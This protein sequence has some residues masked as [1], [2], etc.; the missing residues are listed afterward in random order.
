MG[1]LSLII[2]YVIIMKATGQD[3]KASDVFR[4]LKKVLAWGFGG[5]FALSLL[6][7][8]IGSGEMASVA[9]VVGL[10]FL[11]RKIKQKNTQNN[12]QKEK[13]AK[14]VTKSGGAYETRSSIL[15]RPVTKRNKL[16]TQ[17]NERFKLYLTREQIDRIVDASY[18]S[19]GWKTEIEAMMTQDYV[20]IYEWMQGPTAALR[21]YLYAFHVQK[22]SSDF[23]QQDQIVTDS[24]NEIMDYADT[25]KHLDLQQRIEAVNNKF[26]TAFDDV[27]FMIAFRYLEGKGFRHTLDKVNLE[28]NDSELDE[29]MKKYQKEATPSA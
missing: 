3:E 21:A 20:T 29:M 5:L 22:I 1:I 4:I 12:Y 25:L 8:V 11:L 14:T 28:R 10:L 2:V 24:L 17:F 23:T 6:T 16:V 27:T 18:V 26:F 19:A 7:S 15:P 9:A 13:K